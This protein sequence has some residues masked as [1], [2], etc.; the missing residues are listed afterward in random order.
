MH[1]NVY[2]WCR[3]WHQETYGGLPAVDPIGPPT[4][5][6][7]VIRGGSFASPVRQCLSPSRAASFEVASSP[8]VG[9]RLILRP[10][11]S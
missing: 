1:G 6:K 8:L 7:R 10:G 4:G 2:E 11:G 5:W 3:D 9:F